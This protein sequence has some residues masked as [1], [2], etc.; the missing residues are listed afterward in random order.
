MSVLSQFVINPS[1][2]VIPVA[3]CNKKAVAICNNSIT[4]QVF[5]VGGGGRVIPY[6]CMG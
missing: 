3:T 5:G 2:F 6:T 4:L 1:Y